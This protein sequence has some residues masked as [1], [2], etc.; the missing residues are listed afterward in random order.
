MPGGTWSVLSPFVAAIL[1]AVFSHLIAP[2]WLKKSH[3]RRAARAGLQAIRVYV[4]GASSIPSHQH[5]QTEWSQLCARMF[6][7]VAANVAEMG[8]EG[9]DLKGPSSLLAGWLSQAP[10][11][12]NPDKK[13]VD[14]NVARL[15][16][17][18]GQ[19]EDSLSQTIDAIPQK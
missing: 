19:F 14:Q 12:G 15:S 3:C 4:A 6:G 1:V 5:L 18:L 9:P 8:T 16:Q 11:L 2:A 7:D 17:H 13:I 10:F